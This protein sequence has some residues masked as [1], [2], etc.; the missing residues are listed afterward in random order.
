M[1]PSDQP[2]D[3]GYLDLPQALNHVQAIALRTQ[4]E[5]LRGQPLRL[6]AADCTHLGG[7]GAELLLAA[8]AEWTEAGTAFTLH[9]MTEK[10]AAGAANLG[11]QRADLFQKDIEE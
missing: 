4:I 2:E 9:N 11:L 8:H 6:N 5:A 1:S 10:F 3:I 7:A